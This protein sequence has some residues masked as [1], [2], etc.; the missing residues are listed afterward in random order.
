MRF[1]DSILNRITMYRLVVYELLFL[2]AAALGLSAL[3]ILSFSP[4]QLGY[5][6]ALIFIVA[7]IVNKV[8]AYFFDA[9]SNP[10]S[11]YITALILALIIT[12]P[13]GFGD[14]QFLMLAGWA[15]AWAIVSKYIFAIRKKHIFNP[16]AFGVAVPALFLNQAAS[17]WVGTP[18][19]LPF[20]LIGG[21]LVARKV[22]RLGMVGMFLG[23]FLVTTI[24]LSS[25]SIDIIQTLQHAFIYAPAIFFGT[26]MLT[27]PLT[28]PTDKYWRILFAGFV[29]FLFAP[30]VHAGSFYFTP[31]LAL[32]AGNVFAYLVNSKQKLVLT[33]VQRIPIAKDTYEFVFSHD[34]RLAFTP[35]QYLE[36]T[37]PHAHADSRGIRRYFTISSSPSENE[38]RIG[39]KFYTPASSFKTALFAMRKGDT[40]V[41]SQLAG[42][43]VLPKNPKKKLVF[44][45]GGIGVT[46]FSSMIESLLK[47]QE[48][49]DIVMLY[50][51]RT[52]EDV[53][54]IHLLDRAERELGIETLPIISDPTPEQRAKKEFP[55]MIDANLIAA[56]IPD[57]QE[58]LFYIS[59]PHAMITAFEDQLKERGIP[60]R[61]IKTDFFPGFA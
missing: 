8:F 49:R 28:A 53:A 50:S 56:E 31:E 57:Y 22:R 44:I 6:V 18:W 24:V 42:D 38:I 30:Q 37:L 11:T 60:K 12:P 39:V 32:L 29:G 46:P 23:A 26:V 52:I 7:W 19:M 35:G 58:R 27:E 3:G 20:V 9:P 4:V 47:K 2:L 13:Q 61:N 34:G 1:I 51:N 36:W 43:F 59:G 54:Y 55:R 45:A 17:W 33:L 48:R 40:L 14:T 41:A 16:A 15:A 21:F 5:S 10:E 25:G